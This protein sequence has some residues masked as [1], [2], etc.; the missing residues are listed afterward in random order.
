[1]SM[2]KV[3][4][5]SEVQ[6][7]EIAVLG[8]PFDRN[9]SFRRGPALAPAH[10]REAL[11]SESTNM[12][13][14]KGVDLGAMT[15]WKFFNDLALPDSDTE[16][17][18][19]TIESTIHE[20]LK[21]N[22]RVVA[23]GGD[24]SITYPIIRAYARTYSKLSILQLDAHPDLYDELHH[25]RYSHASQ[26]ARIMEENLVQ[27]LVQVG[28][29]SITGHQREQAKRFNV[30][31]IDMIEKTKISKLTFTG[32]VYL[33]LDMDCLDPAFAPGV[34]HHEPGGMSTREVIEIIQNLKG[35][36]VGADITELNPE[37]D[38]LKITGMVA[39][40][41]LKEILGRM[42]EEKWSGD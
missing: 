6:S 10:I 42:L 3:T 34:S 4:K 30:E 22:A 24:H 40:K 23:V 29:R 5:N 1:L 17:A 39:G 19:A 36:L 18:F 25:N 2:E 13:T 35:N 16:T 12:W 9:S 33:S 14:E 27:R 11:F 26:F 20:L 21:R 28:V 31:V 38:P 15:G 32:P 7:G 8:I 37:L 41:L